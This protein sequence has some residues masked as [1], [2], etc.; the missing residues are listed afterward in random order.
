[1]GAHVSA[2]PNHQTGRTTPLGTRFCVAL[3]GAFGYELD[4][5]KL[6]RKEREAIQLQIRDYHR[7]QKL[8]AQGD[9]LRLTDDQSRFVAW[10]NLSGDRSECLVSLVMRNAEANPRPLHL[11]LKGLDPKAVYILEEQQI[12]SGSEYPVMKQRSF[13][14]AAL[15]YAGITLPALLGDYPSALLY[16]KRQER[17]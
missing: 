13:T 17:A 14:G 11:R 6:S 10:E 15:M 7:W 12:S 3:A 4:P 2:S 8:L 5:G 1:M 16:F 9:Y